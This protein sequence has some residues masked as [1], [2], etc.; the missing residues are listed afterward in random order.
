MPLLLPGHC[1]NTS[2]R[3]EDG[4]LIA[5]FYVP[6]LSCAAQYD[7]M[8]GYFSATALALAVR[9]LEKLIANG[10][11]MRLIVG[12]TLH[13]EEVRA[14]EQG[15]DLRLHSTGRGAQRSPAVDAGT[16]GPM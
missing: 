9:G 8:T 6:A 14:I 11:R 7:R 10:G 15:Y 12:C 16:E 5:L 4:D 3:H 2:I 1:W 13:D